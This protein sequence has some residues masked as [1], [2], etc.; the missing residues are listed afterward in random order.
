MMN[1]IDD[2]TVTMVQLRYRAKGQSHTPEFTIAL[3]LFFIQSISPD[4]VT[5][6]LSEARIG[7][8]TAVPAHHNDAIPVSL[9]ARRHSQK[10]SSYTARQL[11][12][13]RWLITNLIIAL[14]LLTSCDGGSD[15]GPSDQPPIFSA[16][17]ESAT[18]SYDASQLKGQSFTV[19]IV[20]PG[21]RGA[22]PAKE[23]EK[24]YLEA[25]YYT[26]VFEVALPLASVLV[27]NDDCI[28]SGLN[29][30]GNEVVEK[31]VA[32]NTI[33]S[34]IQSNLFYQANL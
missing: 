31:L 29:E 26:L 11:M 2:H 4:S 15:K 13:L 25:T 9:H 19:D 10:C 18:R 23:Y 27:G 30:L 6:E 7:F 24:L 1:A 5:W 32:S 16:G 3:F 22:W 14:L 17:T 28:I 12:K 20:G 34:S 8:S 33:V 21:F